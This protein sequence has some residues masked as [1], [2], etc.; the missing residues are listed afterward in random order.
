MKIIK[1]QSLERSNTLNIRWSPNN[2]CNFTC[3]YCFPDAHAGDFKSPENFNT[4]VSNFQ[5]IF[6]QY[7]SKLNKTKFHLQI[8]GGEPT[9]WKD[10]GKFILEIKK[11][12]NVYVSIV[13]NGS[14]TIRW[15]KE[16][17]GLIDNLTL[18]YHAKDA[19][20]DHMIEVADLMYDL[21]KKVTVF[22]LMD[23]T[24]W[25]KCISAIDYMK[26]SS[27]NSWFII[28]KEIVGYMPYTRMQKEFLSKELKRV[29]KLSW[30]L[31]NY[32]LIFDGSMKILESVAW[33][34]DK[35]LPLIATPNTYINR[36]WT[37]FRGWNC[38]IGI[39][40]LYVSWSGNI[41]GSCGQ[42]LFDQNYNILDNNFVS[43]F[44]PEFKPA[45]CQIER[46]I[47]IPETHLTKSLS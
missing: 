17:G 41:Q 11:S 46:C 14:R 19:D 30:F 16:Y 47:C 9:L 31:K 26:T 42:P 4:V 45:K 7:K 3:N 10:L 33:F 39:D 38:N 21:R 15:W 44:N 28:S 25:Q 22:V 2:I 40:S 5:H 23:P 13:S 8:S 37:D 6:N 27:K 18:S 35:K 20:I 1:I 34:E 32:N 12:H 24:Q 29:P 43:S 36:G